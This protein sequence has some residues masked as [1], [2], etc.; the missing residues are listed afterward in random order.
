MSVSC[1]ALSWTCSVISARN[2][3]PGDG[4]TDT[5][6]SM[7]SLAALTYDLGNKQPPQSPASVPRQR[8]ADGSVLFPTRP[9]SLLLKD[10]TAASRPVSDRLSCSQPSG[11]PTRTLPVCREPNTIF[12][13]P[14]RGDIQKPRL[15]HEIS[16]WLLLCDFQAKNKI[17]G[18]PGQCHCRCY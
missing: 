2:Y 16:S 1:R 5:C 14:C 15:P 11:P 7:T 3:S 18:D 6:H 17:P 12:G 13:W 4:A 9:R 8:A 10:Q